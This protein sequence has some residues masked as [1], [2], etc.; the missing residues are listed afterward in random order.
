MLRTDTASDLVNYPSTYDTPA[1]VYSLRV[2]NY[3]DHPAYR[4]QIVSC[5]P[6]LYRHYLDYFQPVSAQSSVSFTVEVLDS[7]IEPWDNNR[8]YFLI[9]GRASEY[10]GTGPD[11]LPLAELR[12]E[13]TNAK[14]KKFFTVFKPKEPVES[15]NQHGT[16]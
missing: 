15:Q 8:G 9:L 14:G 4:F 2:N 10:V 6:A 1:Y 12:L 11:T 16:V 13:Y 5:N 3:S 7:N